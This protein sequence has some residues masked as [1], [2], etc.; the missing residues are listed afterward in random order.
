MWKESRGSER[1]KG[2]GKEPLDG[3]PKGTVSGSSPVNRVR[4]TTER[5]LS[6]AAY[7][8]RVIWQ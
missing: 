4:P 6:L 2:E 7:F 8:R 5:P 1:W 3:S